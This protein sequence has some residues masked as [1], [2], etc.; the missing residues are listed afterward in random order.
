MSISSRCIK[1]QGKLCAS[2]FHCLPPLET[3]TTTEE[4]CYDKITLLFPLRG[5]KSDGGWKLRTTGQ[6]NLPKLF[7]LLS[8]S[9]PPDENFK[10]LLGE[11]A[12]RNFQ[13]RKLVGRGFVLEVK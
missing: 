10:Q 1:R 7:L 3:S 2:I 4:K 11:T 8:F 6:A 13:Q 5:G 9:F 12:S